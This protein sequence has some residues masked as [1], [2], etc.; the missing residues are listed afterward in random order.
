MIYFSYFNLI[1]NITLFH[2]D[3]NFTA[4]I[5]PH[6]K[7]L[8]LNAKEILYREDDLSDEIYFICKGKM[9]YINEEG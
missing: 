2:K 7:L 9:K 3:A 1:E 5:I 4:N 6:L 8:K